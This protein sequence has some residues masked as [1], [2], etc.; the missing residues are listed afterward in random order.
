MKTNKEQL[1]KHFATVL[2]NLAL[3]KET[4]SLMSKNLAF[5]FSRKELIEIIKKRFDGTI[6]KEHNL[7]EL[8]NKELLELIGNEMFII[9]YVTEKWSR[10]VSDEKSKPEKANPNS[11]KIQKQKSDEKKD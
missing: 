2:R 9:S 8:E 11:T 6:P 1:M 5:Y 7:V 10:E 3:G 4:E